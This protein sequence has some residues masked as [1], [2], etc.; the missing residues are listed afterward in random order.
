MKK[1]KFI[2]NYQKERVWLEEMAGR[3]WF[4]RN[5]NLGVYYTFEKGEPKKMMYEIDRFNIPKS[6]SLEEIQ[7]KEIFMDMAEELGWQEVTHD[8]TLNYYFCKEYIEGEINELYNDEESR[9]YRAKKFANYFYGKSWELIVINI[10][11]TMVAIIIKGLGDITG[12]NLNWFSW[13]MSFYTLFC[14][15]GALYIYKLGKK[16]ERDFALSREEWNRQNDSTLHKVVKKLILT[17]EGLNKFLQNQAAEGYALTK[18]TMTKYFFEKREKENLVFTMDS[19]WLTNKRLQKKNQ[20]SLQD[21]KD[22][23]GLNN[24]WQV[25]SVKDAERKGWAFVCALENRAIIYSGAV[26]STEALNEE[27]YDKRFRGLSLFGEYG[28]FLFVAG[29]IGGVIGGVISVLMAISG[30]Y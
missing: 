5:I 23:T 13:F 22:K 27:K 18:L 30:F 29:C 6:P 21:K 15:T 28:V 26:E 10:S 1:I 11:F 9:I 24:D 2:V 12:V 3:G 17:N 25:Q 16:F 20:K 4:L 7:H 8:E 19:K 14:C